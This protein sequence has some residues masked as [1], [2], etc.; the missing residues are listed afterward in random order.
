MTIFLGIILSIFG[1]GI[2]QL[3]LATAMPFIVTEIGGEYLYGWVFSSY[4]LASLLTIPIF[5][6]LADLYGK[7]KFYLLG[8]SLFAV[9]TLYGALAPNMENLIVARVIQGLGAG[10]MTPVSIALISELFPP[11]KR[12]RMIGAFSFVQLIANLISPILGSFITKQMGWHWI[13]YI[14]FLLVLVAI[15][16]II[17]DRKPAP[18]APAQSL[19]WTEIDLL[20]GLLFGVFCVLV[21]SFSNSISNLGRLEMTGL[22]LLAGVLTAGLTLF[23]NET[24]HHD[25]IIKLAF[26]QNKVLRQSI[27]SS[28]VAGSIMYGLVTLLPLCSVIFNRNGFTSDESQLLMIFMIGTTLGVIITSRFTNHLDAR[29]PKIV[30]GLSVLGA[31][32][33]YYAVS[34]SQFVLFNILTGLLGL[35]LGAIMATMLI[36]SQNAVSSEDRTVL[37]GLVQLGR[38]LGAS[39]GVTVLTGI[40]PEISQISHPSQFLGAFGLL[41][42]IYLTGVMNEFF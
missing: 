38:Y 22:S 15:V 30:W 7:K 32:G 29:F 6:K 16:L 42:G 25:P 21:V 10:M 5:S 3:I 19:R 33:M 23:W 2:M 1:I 17:M 24:R 36:N 18:A 27:L 4:M 28:L 35:S 41:I 8:M 14:T 20:G 37:S 11:E 9:G 39:V 12:G 34:A 26:F 13:F 40:L 31:A